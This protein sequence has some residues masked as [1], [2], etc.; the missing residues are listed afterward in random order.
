MPECQSE[1]FNQLRGYIEPG[2]PRSPTAQI[3]ESLGVS[4]GN[5]EVM[6]SR[7][8]RRFRQIIR[9]KVT[10]TL[11]H[12]SDVDGELTYLRELLETRSV[13]HSGHGE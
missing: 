2:L 3:A 8:R 1:V 4:T 9:E 10:A 12:R 6:K 13:S 11:S 5:V 7:L